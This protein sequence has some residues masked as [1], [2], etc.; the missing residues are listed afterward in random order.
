MD[1]ARSPSIALLAQPAPAPFI[2]PSI[3]EV[4]RPRLLRTARAAP[5]Y[6]IRRSA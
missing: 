6:P 1:E 4:V 2:C 5:F 3:G